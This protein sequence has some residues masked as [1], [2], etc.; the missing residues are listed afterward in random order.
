M[1]VNLSMDLVPDPAVT[2]LSGWEFFKAT[3]TLTG[4]GSGGTVTI[5]LDI[6]TIRSYWVL[7]YCNAQVTDTGAATCGLALTANWS[8][9]GS[10]TG[11]GAELELGGPIGVISKA[12]RESWAMV[13]HPMQ[14]L[15]LYLGRTRQGINALVFTWDVN[16]NSKVYNASLQ[17]A[18]RL[19]R[20]KSIPWEWL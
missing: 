3:G 16:T 6:P 12:G 17:L 1:A 9:L 8:R 7:L 15:P 18:R 20:P 13:D 10:P 11:V 19:N 4:D 5:D 14:Y 2:E